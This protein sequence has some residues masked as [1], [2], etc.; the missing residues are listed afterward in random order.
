M[1]DTKYSLEELNAIS[2]N[3]MAET[4]GIEFTA[5]AEDY[6]E[7]KMPV[8]HRTV[9]PI[10]ILNGGASAALA[11]TVGSV[12]SYLSVDRSKA[13]TV[14]LEIKC[15]HV[16]SGLSGFVVGRAEPVHI[17]KQ[18]HV[19]SINIKDEQGRLVCLSTLTMQVQYFDGNERAME[20]LRKSP[21]A[22][23]SQ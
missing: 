9:Q 11:E 4:L 5:I 1:I 18:T 16:R 12:A 17:G 6:L 14:G 13:Y 21:L 10:G 8:D 7:A 2:K 19:W 20:M 23:I 22:A 3:T 15:N